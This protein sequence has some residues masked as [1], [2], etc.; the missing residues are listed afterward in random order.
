[1]CSRLMSLCDIFLALSSRGAHRAQLIH[2]KQLFDRGVGLGGG[3]GGGGKEETLSE[4]E[5]EWKHA[6]KLGE[7]TG[8]ERLV[9][10]NLYLFREC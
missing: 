5:D 7:G 1:M 10:I 6:G 2:V 9:L 3:G 4:G 8:M